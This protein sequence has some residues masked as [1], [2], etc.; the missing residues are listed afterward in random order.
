M[1]EALEGDKDHTVKHALRDEPAKDIRDA[2]D[3]L[4]KEKYS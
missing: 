4:L 2:V 3:K 1:C